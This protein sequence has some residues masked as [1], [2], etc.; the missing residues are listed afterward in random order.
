MNYFQ[1]CCSRLVQALL[2]QCCA[3]CGEAGDN[4]APVCSAC[5]TRLRALP[6]QCCPTCADF[7]ASATVC[8]HCLT[9]PPAYAGVVSAFL[10]AE[11]IDQLVHDLKYG[12]QLR[13]A[14]WFGIEL[15]SRLL[16]RPEVWRTIDVIVPLPLHPAR[17][18]TRGFNQSLEIARPLARA[19]NKPLLA[20]I[21]WRNRDTPPQATL[22][23]QDR[24]HNMRN[25]FE[26]Q[27]D[28]TGKTILIIDDV[29]TTGS[30][31]DELARVLRLHGAAQVFVACAARTHHH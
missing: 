8:G 9:T 16:E 3:L 14:R 7:S 23:R 19:L 30:S 18:K 21:A 15:V 28:L 31:V 26:C 27:R 2:P 12:H 1:D 6:T 13:I 20:T 5:H 29:L 10:Y 22:S 4:N 25:A 24:Q 11:P 17:M